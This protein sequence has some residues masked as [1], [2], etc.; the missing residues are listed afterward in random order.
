ML[1]SPVLQQFSAPPAWPALGG[2]RGGDAP[3]AEGGYPMRRPLIRS[4]G[5]AAA[6]LLLAH[7]VTARSKE[8][9][10]P[11]SEPFNRLTVDEVARRLAD[12]KAHIYDGNSDEEYQKG[13]LP[14][15]VHLWSKDITE[16]VLPHDK[17]T[18]LIFY[19]HNER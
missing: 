9:K 4:L 2:P 19:C 12:P 5:F 10:K 7:G 8:S 6:V 17:N 18:A 15:A 16:R 14:G 1:E 13:H 3:L 11:E